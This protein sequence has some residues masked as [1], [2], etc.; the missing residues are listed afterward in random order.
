MQRSQAIRIANINFRIVTCTSNVGKHWRKRLQSYELN[1]EWFF[2]VHQR[3]QTPTG[4]CPI[5]LWLQYRLLE[6][7]RFVD[8]NRFVSIFVYHVQ[9]INRQ[10]LH[11]HWMQ[12]YVTT[13]GHRLQLIILKQ[14]WE[15][16]LYQRH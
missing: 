16:A 1:V 3:P 2:H 9:P 14:E 4:Y 8:N 11:I 13:F 6:S 12:L 15:D 7:V 5:Y 10:F